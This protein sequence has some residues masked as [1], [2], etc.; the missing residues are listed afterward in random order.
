[1]AK[2]SIYFL[3]FILYLGV[4]KSLLANKHG[5]VYLQNNY[6]L[7]KF[8]KGNKYT[9]ILQN[10]TSRGYF[11]KS[12][13]LTYKII[14]PFNPTATTLK[15]EVNKNFYYEQRKD[16]GLSILRK[17]NYK[18][19]NIIPSLA[20]IIFVDDLNFGKWMINKSGL[21]EWHFHQSFKHLYQDLYWNDY[22]PTKSEYKNFKYFIKRKISLNKQKLP[23]L[24]KKQKNKI[25]YFSQSIDIP[26]TNIF[27]NLLLT[28]SN[29]VTKNEFNF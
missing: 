25:T 10:A 18:K 16:I 5:N 9:V 28:K 21:K 24:F 27:K 26:I 4:Y 20:G 2:L 17:L 23:F 13:Y 11:I 15:F 3:F 29:W 14:F 6:E 1:M 19:S 8:I 22:R 7:S 12:Y